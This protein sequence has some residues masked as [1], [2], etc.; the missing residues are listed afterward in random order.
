LVRSGPTGAVTR[1]STVVATDLTVDVVVGTDVIGA[2]VISGD[3]ESATVEPVAVAIAPVGTTDGAG[4]GTAPGWPGNGAAVAEP[5]STVDTMKASTIPA[6]VATRTY[7][8]RPSRR[9]RRGGS[10]PGGSSGMADSGVLTALIYH[11]EWSLKHEK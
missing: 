1:W 2:P 8:G 10:M 4:P 9:W 5:A 11:L 7:A 3:V 6:K